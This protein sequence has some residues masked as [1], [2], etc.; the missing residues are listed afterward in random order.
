MSNKITVLT[1]RELESNPSVIGENLAQ[2]AKAIE[3]N[4]EDL[5]DIKNRG[6]WDKLTNNNT[7]DLAEAMIKQNDTI[8][9]FLIIVQGIIFLSM[10]NIVILGGVMDALNKHEKTGEVRDNIYV[11][12]AKDYLGEAIKSAKKVDENK[13]QIN[14]IQEKLNTGYKRHEH[15]TQLFEKMNE[16]L[17]SRATDDFIRDKEIQKI[18]KQ[19]LK[20]FDDY[21]EQKEISILLNK[22]LKDNKEDND[23]EI[24]F[25]NEK[26]L[27]L[28]N[29]VTKGNEKIEIQNS[30]IEMLSIEVEN[31]KIDNGNL[32]LNYD[33][34]FIR[35]KKDNM[36]SYT[37]GGLGILIA[38]ASIIL[39]YIR[40]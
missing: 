7:R 13:A 36:I 10:N 23:K 6:F 5:S 35:L 11:S 22:R 1:K 12:M 29:L 31:L 24:Y 14:M 25:I 2:L 40:A 26:L 27:S 18:S 33:N 30:T 28:D 37:F 38:I 34:L 15:Q 3:D 20:N 4:K 8:S 21:N 9:G 17:K 19:I 32:R 16:E 39:Q